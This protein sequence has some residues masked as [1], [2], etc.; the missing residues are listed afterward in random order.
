LA[1]RAL[2]QPEGF[3]MDEWITEADTCARGAKG[4]QR[5]NGKRVREPERLM[6]SDIRHDQRDECEMDVRTFS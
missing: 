3:A 2:I 5:M 6:I 4:G 1:K